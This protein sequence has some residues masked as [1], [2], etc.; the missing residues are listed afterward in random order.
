[1]KYLFVFMALVVVLSNGETYP[2]ANA[3]VAPSSTAQ[4]EHGPQPFSCEG[5]HGV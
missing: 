4:P 2:T 5:C 3:A 1:M